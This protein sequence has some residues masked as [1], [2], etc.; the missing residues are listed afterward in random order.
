MSDSPVQYRRVLL[1]LSGEAL[2]GEL[3]YGIE[4]KVI[5]RI[6]GEIA[7]ARAVIPSAEPRWAATAVLASSRSLR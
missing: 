3:D 6:A 7:T 1:K 2:M 4:P 5:Q